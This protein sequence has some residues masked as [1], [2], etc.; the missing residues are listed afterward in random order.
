MALSYPY[1]LNSNPYI[2]QNFAFRANNTENQSSAPLAK[3]I[4][5]V[6][7]TI[8]NSVDS[9][10]KTMDEEKEKKSNKK[11]IA[12]GS[13]VLVLTGLVALLNPKY[14]SKFVDKLKSWS[15][16]AGVR[17]EKNKNDYLASKFHKGCQKA[18]NWGIR[19]LEFSN[20]INSAKDI[21]FKWLC[22]EK[23][24]F[25]N[26]KN[27]TFR[28]FLQKIDSGF[29]KIMSKV[30]NA[31]TVWFDKISKKTVFFKYNRAS[32]KMNEFEAL[33]KQYRSKLSPAQ[34][35]E[36]DAKLLEITKQRQFFSKSNTTNRLAEQE[37]LM[38]N[39]ERDFMT[40]FNAYRK[41]F[42]NRWVN[43]ADHIDKN[44]TFW[45][46]KILEPTRN[47]V[48]KQGAN[49]VEKIIGNGKDKKGLYDDI[50]N[51]LSENINAEEK[52]LLE[53]TM[54]K[55]GKK[56]R[57]ANFSECV[58]YF[59][60]K[61]DLVLG[62]APTDIVT[63]VAG[64]GISGAAIATADSKEERISRALTGGF[65]VIAGIGASMAFTA[66]LFSG[67][68]GLLLGAATSVGLSKLGS[69]ADNLITGK[70][71]EPIKNDKKPTENP[72][73]PQEV[74]YA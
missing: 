7:K 40:Q 22:C 36:L 70:K 72:F 2:K 53:K 47:S 50:Y 56:L 46:E 63:A 25:A 68:Q 21:G 59:D 33:A 44:M 61:R 67:V 62:G 9:F 28:K 51:L 55:A 37:N 64:L 66:M 54:N 30:H 3:P 17:F 35:K 49:A 26:V 11:A 32:K 18:L 73:R 24:T 10:V 69:I 34:Q 23:K 27:K 20:N 15:T 6:Q 8:E 4:E 38:G 29:V 57:K 65:P 52:A 45:A 71:D 48:E 58:E 31:I 12:V 13:S 42:K 41:G 1:N 43:K 19:T 74:Q 14:S 60:K 39:L 5:S 16:K